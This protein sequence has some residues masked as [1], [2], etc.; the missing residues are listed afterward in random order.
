M[1]P[2]RYG[3]A[4]SDLSVGYACHLVVFAVFIILLYDGTEMDAPIYE[5]SQVVSYVQA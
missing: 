1:S 4:R 2:L 5:H 3:E